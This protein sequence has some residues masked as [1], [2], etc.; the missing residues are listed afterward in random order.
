MTALLVG[1][2]PF[3][4]VVGTAAAASGDPLA[5]WAGTWLIYSGSAHLA[6][7]GGISG[8]QGLLAIVVTGLLVNARLLAFSAA[9]APELEGE[10][11]RF[12]VVAAVLLVDP[13]W[14]LVN[15]RPREYALRP[16]YLGAG[17]VLFS[18]WGTAVSVGLLLGRSPVAT[19][20]E[21]AIP[22]CLATLVVPHARTRH[23][24]ACVTVGILVGLVTRSWPSGTGVLAGMIAG[25]AAAALVRGRTS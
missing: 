13:L 3:G 18:G 11:L 19:A 7:L 2:V 24:A 17:V 16:Y 1:L 9:L 12:R 22:V 21:V 6:V 10:S 14:A 25:A 15:A 23:G 8:G 20:A 4:L 5:G